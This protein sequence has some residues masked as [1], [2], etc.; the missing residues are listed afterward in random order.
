MKA[1]YQYR[2]YPTNQQAKE[3][4]KLFGCCRV[5]WNDA[6][7]W[8]MQTPEDTEWPSNAELQKLC[9][10]L[11]KQYPQRSWLSKVSNVPLQQSVQDLGV[12]FKNFYES[13]SGKRQ[14]PKVR[15]PK[16][17]RRHGKQS[18]RFTKSGFSC[19]GSKLFL[20]K[21]GLFKVKWSRKL[22]AEPS[23]VTILRSKAGQ[24]YASFVV[25][26]QQKS[27]RAKRKSIG[28]D[29]GIKVFAFPSVGK[30]VYSPSYDRLNRLIARTNRKLARQ[31][32]G[33]NRWQRTKLKLARL[34]LKVGNTRKDFLHKQSTKL[35]RENQ[36]VSLE[37]LNVKGMLANRR[38][39]RAISQQGWA[40]FRTMC[41]AKANQ[42]K[43]RIVSIISRWE[44]TSQTCSDCGFR[45]GKIAL[46]VRSILCVSCGAE[47]DRD[48]NAAKNIDRVGA[49]HVHNRQ[50]R[51]LSEC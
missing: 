29:L 26:V 47:H 24:Y 18:A 51:T 43:D 5:V 28:V 23:S 8:V 15:F 41:E 3:L 42:Y 21:M 4:S 27:V 48:E 19:K 50:K 20:A 34:H 35:I 9:I 38:L 1:R 44:P 7:A 30:P 10:T 22:P 17:K 2:I 45:W 6:L 36:T 39:S 40:Q 14:G 16:F 37:N 25:E 11:A 12:A 13:C 33:S 32:K 46:S 49:G 31:V